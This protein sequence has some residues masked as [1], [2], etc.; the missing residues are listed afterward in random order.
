M[1][2]P[3]G[4][5]H[6]EPPPGG[7]HGEAT[8]R[9]APGWYGR[10]MANPQET[11]FRLRLNGDSAQGPLTIDEIVR[12]DGDRALSRG[13]AFVAVRQPDGSWDHRGVALVGELEALP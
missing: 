10:G 6:G 13:G 3:P 12:M 5:V 4:G 9:A 8:P 2:W 11:W 7:V 1:R